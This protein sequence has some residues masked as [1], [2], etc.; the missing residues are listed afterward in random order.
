[1]LMLSMFVF[2]LLGS[3]RSEVICTEIEAGTVDDKYC[4]ATSKPDDTQRVC[5][6]HLCPARYRT[7]YLL[8]IYKVSI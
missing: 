5:N 6:E 7:K 8:S 1:M 3:Q 4:N 2:L